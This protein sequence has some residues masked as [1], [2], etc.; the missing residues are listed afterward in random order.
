VDNVDN[1]DVDNP[2]MHVNVHVGDVD[3]NVGAV[4][5]MPAPVE[6][7][8]SSLKRPLEDRRSAAPFL[9]G[10]SR[11]STGST[12]PEEVYRPSTRGQPEDLAGQQEANQ[13][14]CCI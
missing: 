6:K 2:D 10:C 11:F 13:F 3:N 9:P 1:L 7:V 4:K 5:K 12:S 8:A 14:L